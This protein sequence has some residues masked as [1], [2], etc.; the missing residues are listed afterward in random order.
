MT[1]DE[2]MEWA[3]K[4]ALEYCDFGDYVGALSSFCSDLQKHAETHNHPAIEHG[5]QQV[6]NGLISNCEQ[7]RKFI[8]G[9]A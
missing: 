7:M 1:R 6:Y 3:K 9:C 8:G 2:H 4:R 5:F